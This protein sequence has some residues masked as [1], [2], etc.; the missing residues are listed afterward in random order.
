MEVMEIIVV[1]DR[2]PQNLLRTNAR[3]SNFST[4]NKNNTNKNTVDSSRSNNTNNNRRFVGFLPSIYII[5]T[6][7]NHAKADSNVILMVIK[8]KLL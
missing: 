7:T 8:I 3:S 1:V 4:N 2:P 6:S 5:T